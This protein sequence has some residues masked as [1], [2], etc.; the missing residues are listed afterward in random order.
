VITFGIEGRLADRARGERIGDAGDLDARDLVFHTG[1]TTFRLNGREVTSPLLGTHN[2]QNLLAALCVGIG[3]SIPLEDLLPGVATLSGGRQRLERHEL[4]GVTV[5]DDSYNA[6]PESAR[7]AVR[8]L[9]GLHGYRRRVL[10]LGDMLELG[11]LAAELHHGLGFEA[12]R[13]GIDRIVVV[14]ELARAVAAGAL[15][16]GL[17]AGAVV[18]LATTDAAARELPALVRAGDVVLVKG[19]R[20]MQLE[21]VVRALVVARGGS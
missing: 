19:S 3:L 20:R 14:G 15:E 6:N 9:A 17:A 8:V 5:L 13:A 11:E 16:G 10:V 2:A 18:H 1:G 4:A 7:A 21:R 12:A